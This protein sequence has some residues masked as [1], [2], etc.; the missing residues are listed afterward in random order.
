MVFAKISIVAR[1]GGNSRRSPI[2][3]VSGLL[4][5]A[6][7]RPAHEGGDLRE[8]GAMEYIVVAETEG[9]DPPDRVGGNPAGLYGGF[10]SVLRHSSRHT[11]CREGRMPYAP[12]GR[13]FKG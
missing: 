13:F 10:R 11:V 8:N 1:F 9:N 4:R 7:L 6:I 3:R 5:R 12:T 2:R